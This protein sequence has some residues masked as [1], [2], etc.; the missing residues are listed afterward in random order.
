MMYCCAIDRMLFV[1]QYST[2]PAGKKKNITEKASGMIHIIRACTGSGGVGFSQVC[3]IVVPVIRS[4][5]MKYGSFAERSVTQPSQ[6]AFLIS[7]V[8]SST[9]YSA[10]K[11]GI[12]TRMGRQPPSGLTF[13]SL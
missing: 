1:S 9:E 10:M 7:T 4:G 12:C 5:R 13:S 3:S 11:K 2:R 6:G 8:D